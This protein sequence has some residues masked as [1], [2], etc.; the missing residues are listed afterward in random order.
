MQELGVV[1]VGVERVEPDL[2]AKATP[3]NISINFL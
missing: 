2:K 3:T 1:Q